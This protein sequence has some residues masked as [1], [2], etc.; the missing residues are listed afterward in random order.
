MIKKRIHKYIIGLFVLTALFSLIPSQAFAAGSTIYFTP[1]S[2]SSQKGKTFTVSVNGYVQPSWFGVGTI[3]GKVTFPKNLLKVT[4]V[5]DST[6]T[7]PNSTVTPNNSNGNIT[8]EQSSEWYDRAN[9]QTIH[10]FTITFQSLKAGTAAVN[11]SDVRY[12]SGSPAT[13]NGSYTITNPPAPT[14]SPSPSP[15]PKPTPKPS[16]SPTPKPT[17]KPSPSP[18]VTPRPTQTPAPT[19]AE[20]EKEQPT[21]ESEGNLRIHNVV[22]NTTR[23]E[24]S[25][26]WTVNNPEAEM[27]FVYGETKESME[28][29]TVITEND[30]GSYT[31]KLTDVKLGTLYYY[32][33]RAATE[34]NL[35]GST[36]SGSLTTRGYPVQLTIQQNGLLLPGA[37]VKIAGRSF[38]AN[39]NAI[40]LTELSEGKHTATITP[41]DTGHSYEISFAVA[42]KTIPESGNPDIQSILLNSKVEGVSSGLSGSLLPLLGGAALLALLIG[43]IAAVIIIQRRR[44]QARIIDTDIDRNFLAANYDAEALQRSHRPEP[45]ISTVNTSTEA[46]SN[47]KAAPDELSPPPQDTDTGA[48]VVAPQQTQ[49]V[50]NQPSPQASLPSAA[51]A[52]N[53]TSPQPSEE[54]VTQTYPSNEAGGSYTDNTQPSAAEYAPDLVRVEASDEPAAIYNAANGELDIIHHSKPS[55]APVPKQEAA[56]PSSLSPQNNS[57]RSS[58]PVTMAVPQ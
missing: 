10:L 1:A 8:F 15:T 21:E 3:S 16:P 4:N 49:Q 50:N 58:P 29:D 6:S 34:D 5:N 39:N 13:S 36:Y 55:H 45:Q 17:P 23:Q 28:R 25:V 51:S 12:E 11:F 7:F 30:N 14:P 43:S 22:V 53:P 52:P 44:A 32:T 20:E 27:T 35:Q 41:S 24:N 56:T 31:A 9:D 42:K 40:V 37:K 57:P 33:I 18:S 46:T 26:S 48:T 38:T 54:A 19:P 2:G 47:M